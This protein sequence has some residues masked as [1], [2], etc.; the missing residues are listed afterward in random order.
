MVMSDVKMRR[1]PAWRRLRWLGLAAVVLA[2]AVTAVE[3]LRSLAVPLFLAG[4]GCYVAVVV[5][6]GQRQP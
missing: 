6:G 1:D 2:L 3:P 4:V 5:L